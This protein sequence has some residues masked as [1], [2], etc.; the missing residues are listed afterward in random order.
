MTIDFHP[1]ELATLPDQAK[2]QLTAMEGLEHWDLSDDQR[3]QLYHYCMYHSYSGT[4]QSCGQDH[5]PFAITAPDF[6]FSQGQARFLCPI[7]GKRL[8][9][10]HGMTF[11]AT[12]FTY[13]EIDHE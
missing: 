11:G 8:E 3:T 4:C 1:D 9:L 6:T 5:K 7:T 12:H 13:K 2:A 10:S